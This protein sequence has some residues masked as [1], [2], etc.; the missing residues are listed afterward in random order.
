MTR[1]G[2][3]RG[4][5]FEGYRRRGKWLRPGNAANPRVGSGMQQ[6]RDL[7]AEEAVEA[8]RNREDGTRLERGSSGPKGE[9]G[10]VFVREWTHGA[11]SMEGNSGANAPGRNPGEE[12]EKVDG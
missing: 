9:G 6:A 4:M 10:N 3:R 7:R 8:V 5:S 12:A 2:C 11:M 1:Y